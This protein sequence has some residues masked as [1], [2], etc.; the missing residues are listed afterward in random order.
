MDSSVAGPHDRQPPDARDRRL[1]LDP[2]VGRSAQMR[3][4]VSAAVAAGEGSGGLVLVGGEP[5]IGKT[6]LVQQLARHVRSSGVQ[7]RWANCWRD[8]GAPA[9]W[10][11]IQLIRAHVH[12]CEPALLEAELGHL[13]GEIARLVPELGSRHDDVPRGPTVGREEARFRLFDGVATFLCR[14]AE[15]RPMLL[16]I[17]D[18]HWADPASVLLLRFLA[19]ELL[20]SRLLVVGTYRDVEIEDR[21]DELLGGLAGSRDH[22]TLGGLT[23]PE[24]AQLIEVS[25]G[26]T[27]SRERAASVHRRTGGNPLFVR[28]LARLQADAGDREQGVPEGVRE[29]I[30]HRLSQLSEPCRALLATAAVIGQEFR[31]D[32]LEHVSGAGPDRL[33]GLLEEAAGARLVEQV[34]SDAASRRFAHSLV[35]EVLY[36]ELVTSRRQELHYRVGAAIEELFRDHLELRLPQL[37]HHSRLA[38]E[39]AARGSALRYATDAGRRAMALLAYEEAADHFE[40]AVDL[41]ESAGDEDS[42]ARC[43]LLLSLAAA[44]MASGEVT[45]GR[46]AC[47]RA[48]GLARTIGAAGLVAEAALG[49]SVGTTVGIVDDLEIRLLE[50]ALDAVGE[51]DSRARARLLVRLAR[52]LHGTSSI[53]HRRALSE[54]AVAIARR[55]G[56]PATLAAVLYDR[57]SVIGSHERAED[58]IGVFNETVRLAN[59]AGDHHLALSA[60]TIR[61][62]N[63][64]ELGDMDAVRTELEIAERLAEE[65]RRPQSRWILSMVR[66]GL[67]ILAGRLDE[68]ERLAGRALRLGRRM[69][70][71]GIDVYHGSVVALIRYLQ[72]RLPEL[73]GALR[74]SVARYPAATDWRC[75]LALALWDAGRV[76]EARREFEILAAQDFTTGAGDSPRP[77][78]LALLALACDAL[79]DARR[80]A[81]LYPTL[82]PFSAHFVQL[83]QTAAGCLGSAAH[84]LGL[85][86]ATLGRWDEAVEHFEAAIRMNSGIGAAPFVANSRFQCALALRA[87]G[88]PAAAARAVEQLD[89]AHSAALALGLRL[90]RGGAAAGRAARPIPSAGPPLTSREREVAW[91]VADG[92]TNG[93]IAERLFI[94]KRTAETHLGHIRRKLELDS[95]V[96]IATWAT[97]HGP[98]PVRTPRFSVRTDANRS[99]VAEDERLS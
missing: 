55:L 45:G 87:L 11:W 71:P 32:V 65:L 12:E 13:A 37:A 61:M 46:A 54:G 95:R 67:E 40:R 74:E 82:S 36:Q 30:R 86:S 66:S 35:V 42:H 2:F 73:E 79:G 19:R 91:L 1:T 23:V 27:P 39:R 81:V 63:L 24:V 51:A 7:L 14:A 56:D 9:F 84:Y 25:T 78:S 69:Q 62:G 90:W 97:R 4:L 33:A 6:R 53:E 44:R 75:V 28:E 70:D 76:E 64:L 57:C 92:L 80:A 85:L 58:R 52:A 29:V 68:G 96:G 99:N 72:G 89:L 50:E 10:P 3:A 49:V 48:A 47:E 93:E 98:P 26:V 20:G 22:L 41:L 8:D 17:E 16:V 83:G 59:Q 60:R 5:G 94:S 18:L 34:A 31:L 38:G 15:T 88:G 77:Y 43:A 21:L